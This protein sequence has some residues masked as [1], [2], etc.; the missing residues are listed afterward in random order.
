MD[1]RGIDIHEI[2]LRQNLWLHGDGTVPG[3][4]APSFERLPA[5]LLAANL[6]GR[7]VPRHQVILGPRRAGKTTVMHQTVRCLLNEGVPFGK[8][9]WASLDHP[10][11]AGLPFDHLVDGLVGSASASWEDPLYLFLDELVHVQDWDFWL[12]TFHDE[13]RPVRVLASVSA[14]GALRQ[15][16]RA[17]KGAGRWEEWPLPPCGLVE[18]L[19][20]GGAQVDVGTVSPL[21]E[22]LEALAGEAVSPPGLDVARRRLVLFGG[23]PEFLARGAE[24]DGNPERR[25]VPLHRA[26]ETL[27]SAVIDRAIYRDI[28]HS[29]RVQDPMAIEFLLQILAGRVTELFSPVPLAG[30]VSVS[31]P[32][33][34]RH[35]KHLVQTWMVF[36]L[37]NYASTG[38]SVRRRGRRIHFL[39]GAVRN[40]VLRLD[41]GALDDPAE[42][43]RLHGN[44]AAAHLRALGEQARV[45]I[46]HWRRGRDEVDFVYD[47]FRGPLAFGFGSSP[48]HRRSGF[49]RFLEAHPRFHGGCYHVAPGLP[50][51]AATET[52]TGVGK[53]PLDALLLVASRQERA[54]LIHR[55]GG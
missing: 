51:Q 55:L 19:A 39:D 14:T 6:R 10:M 7:H 24:I 30:D 1:L 32:T 53:L 52:G 40:A 38:E 54:A 44:L 12:K 4:L 3:D 33:L 9:R 49:R 41:A 13:R 31:V 8:I 28:R 27:R 46:G 16:G 15:Q 22:S 35:L 5:A 34:E 18:A 21:R 17:A 50:F 25:L 42:L 11:L 48:T 47:D 2:L 36:L 29:F 37:P 20:I 43:G 45:R 23:C 26:Q